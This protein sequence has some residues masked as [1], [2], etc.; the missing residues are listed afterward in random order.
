MLSEYS[1][2][3]QHFT[4]LP[5]EQ[6]LDILLFG[7]S[8]NAEDGRRVAECFQSY[9]MTALATRRVAAAGGAAVRLRGSGDNSL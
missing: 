3:L 8:L 5:S 9:I 4:H 7:T 1:E 2:T 6:K